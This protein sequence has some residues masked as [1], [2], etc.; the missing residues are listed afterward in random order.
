[1]GKGEAAFQPGD[2][3]HQHRWLSRGVSAGLREMEAI[4]EAESSSVISSPLR[5]LG[6]G[7]Q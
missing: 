4:V 6:T 2:I 1:M 5:C 3:K 7:V